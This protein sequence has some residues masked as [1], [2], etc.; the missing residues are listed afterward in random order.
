[1]ALFDTH[2]ALC[3]GIFRAW[4]SPHNGAAPCIVRSARWPCAVSDFSLHD[5][6]HLNAFQLTS[7]HLTS[8][9][10]HSLIKTS[11]SRHLSHLFILLRFSYSSHATPRQQPLGHLATTIW[12]EITRDAAISTPM[13]TLTQVTTSASGR[14]LPPRPQQQLSPP[15]TLSPPQQT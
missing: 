9:H 4:L 6:I 10:F 14:R 3:D 11:V 5:V 2:F 7:P 15:Q 12:R 13:P 8:L 1:M